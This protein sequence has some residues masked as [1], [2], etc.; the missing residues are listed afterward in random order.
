MNRKLGFYNYYISLDNKNW[1]HL[2]SDNWKYGTYETETKEYTFDEFWNIV[3]DLDYTR[4]GVTLFKKRRYII[5]F[6][7]DKCIYEDKVN[8]VYLK[9]VFRTD[10]IPTIKELQEELL[11]NE[12]VQFL[13][14]NKIYEGEK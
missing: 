12:Y 10:R 14:E 9:R 11:V 2:Y 7:K 3:D 5:F 13:K 1:H 4:K 6:F 8:K